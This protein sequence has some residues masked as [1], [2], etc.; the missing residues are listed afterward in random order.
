MADVVVTE[1]MNEEAL[2]P[3]RERY[4]VVYDTDLH[5]DRA[6][7]LEHLEGARGIIVR[8]QTVVDAAAIAA[9][10][11]LQVIGRLGVGLDNIDVAAC[12]ARG[13]AVHPAI[14][15]NAVAVAEYVIGALLVVM[16]GVFRVTEDVA[17]GAWPR[18]ALAGLELNGR[19]LGLVGYGAIARLVADRARAL[20]MS[21]IA[22]DPYLE[23]H[24]PAWAGTRQVDL[25]TLFSSSDAVSLHVPLTDE[26]AGIVD[27]TALAAMRSHAVLVNTARGGIVDEDAL[28]EALHAG[29]IGGAALD[30]FA[31]EPLEGAAAARFA[32]VPNLVLTPHIAGNTE[33]AGRRVGAMTVAAVLAALDSG[34]RR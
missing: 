7:F 19:T 10:P 4:T 6:R 30:V 27:A 34:P 2:V 32:G 25:A 31:V 17:S 23:A 5:A 9:A 3:L 33:E 15:A 11:R 13:I 26:T 12:D 29:R 14:G 28:V 1:F 20:G 24:H 22:Y 16:R 21:I 8:N 18:R